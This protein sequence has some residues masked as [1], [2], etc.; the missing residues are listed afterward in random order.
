MTNLQNSVLD[1]GVPQFTA[2]GPPTVIPYMDLFPFPFY[3]IVR[4][5]NSLP[6]ILSD[7][8]RQWFELV[9]AGSGQ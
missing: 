7:A 6:M 8:L 4:E 3:V 1:I 2:K 9:N 5:T